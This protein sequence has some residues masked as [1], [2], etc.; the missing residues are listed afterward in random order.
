MNSHASFWL[1]GLVS[2]F[3]IGLSHNQ[4]AGAAEPQTVASA[5]TH[6]TTI[7]AY[8]KPVGITMTGVN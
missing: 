1:L 7:H 4:C 5:Q 6:S 8:T 3:A 2:V